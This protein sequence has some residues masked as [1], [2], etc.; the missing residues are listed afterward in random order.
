M[1]PLAP[2]SHSPHLVALVAQAERLAALVSR[3]QP[4]EPARWNPSAA[5]TSETGRGQV[6][7]VARIGNELMTEAAIASLRL[8][9]SPI[10]RVP[11]LAAVRDGAAPAAERALEQQPGSWLEILQR[12]RVPDEEVLAREYLGMRAGLAATDLAQ[13]LL[14][15]PQQA[16]VELHRRLTLQL[17]HPDRAGRTRQSR[18]VV[19]DARVGRMLFHPAQPEQIPSQM[20]SLAS[21]LATAA[22]R[23][24]GLVVSGVVHHELLAAHP[25]EAANG[26]L[27]RTAARLLLRVRGLDPGGLAAA[28][29]ALLGDPLGYYGEMSATARRRDLTIWLERWGEAVTS[30]LRLAARRL[31]LLDLDVPPRAEI[32]L[33]RW[34]KPRFTVSDYQAQMEVGLE[35]TR[36]D[37]ER[38]LGAG[39]VER[40]FGSRGLRFSILGW[41]PPE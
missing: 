23:H 1:R 3:V 18:Q 19:H 25:Y 30:G 12:G 2:F 40:V 11:D 41:E 26:R 39:R 24:H 8:D 32:F 34:E 38:M 37:L 13:E 31:G 28:E 21:W 15:S 35:Q 33:G 29:V 14:L 10:D 27:A 16:L 36:A 20:A 4:P 7:E 22:P 5:E 17:L 6:D 9:G